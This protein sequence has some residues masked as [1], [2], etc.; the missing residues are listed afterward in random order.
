MIPRCAAVPISDCC[1]RGGAPLAA[2]VTHCT[3][4]E[5]SHGPSP[6][7]VSDAMGP[8]TLTWYVAASS[9]A[10][11]AWACG[12]GHGRPHAADVRG[13]ESHYGQG[14]GGLGVPSAMPAA[15]L[16]SLARRPRSVVPAST[17]P[18]DWVAVP[19]P[20]AAGLACHPGVR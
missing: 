5:G 12:T 18:V 6:L 7:G 1:E 3:G 13:R 14:T 2:Q 9:L 11:G 20:A 17:A 10:V 8:V 4:G 16:Q 15:V 19:A